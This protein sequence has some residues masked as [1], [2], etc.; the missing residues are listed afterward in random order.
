MKNTYYLFIIL[1]FIACSPKEETTENTQSATGP[2]FIFIL[3]DDLGYGDLSCFGATDIKTPNIDRI[4]AEGVKFTA[5]Y[6]TSPVCSPSRAGLLTGRNSQRMGIHGVFFPESYTGMPSE[7]NTIAE[8][9]KQKGYATG[10]VGK[11]HLGHHFQYLP[12]QQGF[13]EYYGIPYSNDMESVV[14]M[15][16]NEVDS[17]K[18]DQHYTT[19]TYTEK[20]V[21]FIQRN[22][23]K[24]FFL[25]LA[26]NMPHV[27]I[28]A[29]EKFLGSSDRGL[30]GDVIQEID[31]SVGEVLKTLEGNGMLE[32]T[33]IV[34]SSD[35]GPW[36]VMEDHGGS[37]GILREGKQYTFEGGMRVPTVAMWKGKIPPQ[38][39]EETSLQM[40]WLPTFASFADVDVPN[41]RD[42]DGMNIAEA[43]LNQTPMKERDYLYFHFGYDDLRAMRSGKWKIKLPFKGFEGSRGMSAVAAH[44]TLLFNL[45]QDPGET[46]NLASEN[47]GLVRKLSMKM[48]SKR[49]EMG[50]FKPPIVIRSRADNGH[51][52]YLENKHSTEK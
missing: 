35:N 20:A 15:K 13:D 14:Y 40:D 49:K 3:A 12:L 52:E 50:E 41:D 32:N 34:F 10:V 45:E 2:N 16:D 51:F 31:W 24:P 47:S 25:Y 43:L 48:E 46:T 26:H 17:F 21:D 28:Y 42:Y 39:Y 27:P 37:A 19:K 11:W 1:Y 6:T 23:E 9:L 8:L 38:V 44:D 7:E 29:S 18:V 22:K 4:A 30:Y 5:H 33:V 36:L